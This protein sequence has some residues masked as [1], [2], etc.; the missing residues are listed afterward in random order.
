MIDEAASDDSDCEKLPLIRLRVSWSTGFDCLPWVECLYMFVSHTCC[1][2]NMQLR[3]HN[4]GGLNMSSC[5]TCT[6]CRPPKRK[7]LVET[8]FKKYR[9]LR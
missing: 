2:W 1:I 9:M 6:F 4:S 3:M 8:A 7:Q 5:Y